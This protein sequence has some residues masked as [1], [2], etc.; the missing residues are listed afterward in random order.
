MRKEL[1]VTVEYEIVVGREYYTTYGI[2]A[3]RE[4]AERIVAELKDD[5]ASIITRTI[6]KSLGM[7]NTSILTST[8]MFQLEDISLEESK[9]ILEFLGKEDGFT[10]AVGHQATAEILSTILD[11]EAAYL[12]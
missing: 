4:D 1:L 11:V 2:V 6:K 12:S 7:L 9:E 8:G 10:S 3:T 5:S